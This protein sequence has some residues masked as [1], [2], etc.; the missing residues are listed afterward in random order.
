MDPLIQPGQNV[1]QSTTKLK[2]N[3][4]LNKIQA[5]SAEHAYPCSVISPGRGRN[6]PLV[7]SFEIAN[8]NV[9]N[10]L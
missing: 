3:F 9:G 8:L 5:K 4:I 2:L 7:G 1:S 10:L 6:R